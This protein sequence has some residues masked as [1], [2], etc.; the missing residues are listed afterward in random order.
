MVDL[1]NYK[2]KLL[3]YGDCGGN[4]SE[5]TIINNKEM[6]ESLN[7]LNNVI[8]VLNERNAIWVSN[9]ILND[10]NFIRSFYKIIINV[11]TFSWWAAML[12]DAK[13]IY[14]SKNWKY[15]KGVG[16]K[17]LPFVELENWNAVDF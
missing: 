17:N 4:Y 9:S 8:S 12:S 5:S 14:A 3:K 13:E 7:N 6:T 1:N 2:K 11:S 10:F 16:N 15:L